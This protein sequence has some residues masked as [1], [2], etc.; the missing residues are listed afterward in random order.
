MLKQLSL[1]I[2]IPESTKQL[3]MERLRPLKRE[4]EVF[5]W[6]PTEEYNI[7]LF[8]FG[9]VDD[10]KIEPLCEMIE[11][12]IFDLPAFTL[13]SDNL[14][15]LMK[16]NMTIYAGF[17]KSKPIQALVKQLKQA[18]KTENN[19]IFFP[20]LPVARHK[21]GSKQQYFLIKKKCASYEMEF[22]VGITQITLLNSVIENNKLHYETVKEF[23]LYSKN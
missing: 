7:E 16:N 10:S 1:A 8:N 20:H 13:Y 9:K 12:G 6:L 21:I 4:Y 17:H 22:E 5:Q 15:I 23:A 18:F 2:K 19:L 14:H 3:I 11:R